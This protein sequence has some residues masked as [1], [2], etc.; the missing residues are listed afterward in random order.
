MKKLCPNGGKVCYN[1]EEH[2]KEARKNLR[3]KKRYGDV[4]E[5]AKAYRCHYCKKYHLTTTGY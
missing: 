3:W 4:Y 5:N 1:S 2:A